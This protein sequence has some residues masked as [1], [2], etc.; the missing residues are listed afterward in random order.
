MAGLPGKSAF[1]TTYL[2]SLWI[3]GLTLISGMMV[4]RML[5]PEGRGHL[6]GA[7][8]WP[9]LLTGFS[10]LGVNNSLVIKSAEKPKSA[11]EYATLGVI[12]LMPVLAISMALGWLFIPYWTH[13]GDL[14]QI[15]LS[16]WA[17]LLVPSMVVIAL[18]M[19]ID[20]GTGNFRRFNR[21]RNILNPVYL[22]I[23]VGYW[24]WQVNDVS[25]YLAAL[26]IANIA[27]LLFRMS[28]ARFR[29]PQGSS[30]ITAKELLR[31]SFPFAITGVV[32]AVRDNAERLLLMAL[33]P[34]ASLGNYAVASTASSIHLTFGKSLN[35]VLFTRSASQD[36]QN[37][38]IDVAR[39][40]RLMA[41]INLLLGSVAAVI[42]PLLIPIVFGGE[43]KTAVVPAVLL[44]VSQFF[45]SQGSLINEGL[46]AR[47][48]PY[49]GMFGV[50]LSLAVFSAVGI[51]LSNRF[52]L[53]GV[54]MASI[55]GQAFYCS[56]MM[57][58]LKRASPNARLIPEVEDIRIVLRMI[59]SLFY[60]SLG[61]GR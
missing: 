17:L 52:G 23:L 47:K 39:L 13:E 36:E 40:F 51:L 19:A 2:S 42:L 14:E 44:I 57:I 53:I 32:Y 3:Q 11:E 7:L 16:R 31:T 15:R 46:R 1:F 9:S 4:A 35:T 26:T 48:K 60:A 5:G 55:V 27:T 24:I 37:A 10:L 8:V 58:R 20:Q 30:L 45:L 49:F 12:I 18:L 33:L 54:A 25:W 43:F 6:A 29:I 21:T 34:I 56:H 38:L 28:Y 22:V 50:I 41:L 61:R 59:K